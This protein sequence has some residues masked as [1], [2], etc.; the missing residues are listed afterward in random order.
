MNCKHELVS[1]RWTYIVGEI[2]TSFGNTRSGIVSERSTRS[3][4]EPNETPL[5]VFPSALA[6]LPFP[7]AL[8]AELPLPAVL[9]TELPS[10]FSPISNIQE[11]QQEFRVTHCHFQ[12]C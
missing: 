7:C 11:H 10:L 9:D 1:P 12:P 3:L 4:T 5:K 2:V 6:E 8:E